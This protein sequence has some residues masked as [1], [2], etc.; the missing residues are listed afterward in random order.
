MIVNKLNFGDEFVDK[1][2]DRVA[3]RD[4][5]NLTDAVGCRLERRSGPLFSGEYIDYFLKTPEGKIDLKGAA[6]YTSKP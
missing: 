6:N 1:N 2:G 3:V 4:L 5:I